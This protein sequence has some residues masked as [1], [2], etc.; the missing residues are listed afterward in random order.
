MAFWDRLHS[1]VYC[2]LAQFI[3]FEININLNYIECNN[4]LNMVFVC[5]LEMV[6]KFRKKK[7][8]LWKGKVSAN[9]ISGNFERRKTTATMKLVYSNG[10]KMQLI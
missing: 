6:T 3:Q 7:N 10:E 8:E 9:M 4:V 1:S 2:A 5:L